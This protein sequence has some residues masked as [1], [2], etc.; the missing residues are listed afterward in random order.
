MVSVKLLHVPFRGFW[1][2]FL[3]KMLT[4]VHREVEK[5]TSPAVWHAN[6]S[7]LHPVMAASPSWGCLVAKRV[8]CESGRPRLNLASATSSQSGLRQ[9]PFSH[10]QTHI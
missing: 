2:L 10:P 8:C 4:H 6:V 3:E 5:G 1:V 9:A 7:K